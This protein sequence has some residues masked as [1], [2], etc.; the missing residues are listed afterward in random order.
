MTALALPTAADTL[1]A[2]A[3]LIA[4]RG[5][6]RNNYEGPDG[7]LDPAGAVALVL[8]AE[9]GVWSQPAEWFI[10]SGAY[11]I[12]FAALYALVDG[13]GRWSMDHG[14]EPWDG[15]AL[16]NH[17]GF[18]FEDCAPSAEVV[19]HHMHVAAAVLSAPAEIGAAR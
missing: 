1:V 12:G 3:G 13:V 15:E 6:C 10:E 11:D 19:L 5:L 18:W 8:G 14:D 2:A 16:A 4:R 17:L 7:S 9:P